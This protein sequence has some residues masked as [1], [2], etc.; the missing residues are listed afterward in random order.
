[1][2]PLLIALCA[3]LRE[4]Y[5]RVSTKILIHLGGKAQIALPYLYWTVVGCY[6]M[7]I[8]FIIKSSS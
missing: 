5:H 3:S 4:L 2:A 8:H 1:M 7:V 6:K